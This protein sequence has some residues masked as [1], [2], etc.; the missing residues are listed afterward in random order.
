MDIETRKRYREAGYDC[1]FE[2]PPLE[3]DDTYPDYIR[4]N[5]DGCIEKIKEHQKHGDITFAF[6]TDFHYF[7]L[8]HHDILLERNINAYRSI[9]EKVKCDKLIFGG[10]YV[11][12]APKQDKLEGFKKLSRAFLPFHYLPVHGNHDAS[13]LWDSFMENETAMNKISKSEV[14]DAFYRHVPA[15]GAVFDKNHKGLYYYVDDDDRQVRYIMIDICDAPDQYAESIHSPLCISQ[16]QLE[17][18][19]NEALMTQKDIIVVTH[20]VR[21]DVILDGKPKTYG[22]Y[23]GVITLILDTYKNGEKLVDTLYEEEFTLQ[24][25]VDFSNVE[26]GTIL[27]VFAGHFHNDLVEYTKSGIPCVFTA[28]FNMSVC[29][30]LTPR[31]VGDKSELLFD[32]VTVDRDE[33][34]L[35]LTR[36]G[37]GEDRTVRY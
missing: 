1:G 13:S 22:R 15:E 18:L 26:R 27:G 9:C 37:A 21:R 4:E 28:N 11:I 16:S 7:P 30:L 33:R 12:D 20:S 6:M 36:V 17:W 8:P 14:Y 23:L 34:T 5:V 10:D 24:V 32:I 25:N 3:S 2:N 35:H 29:R 31:V 19:A